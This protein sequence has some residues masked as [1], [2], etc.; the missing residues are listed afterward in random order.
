MW[1][2]ELGTAIQLECVHD[3]LKLAHQTN[4]NSICTRRMLEKVEAMVEEADRQQESF[5]KMP[6]IRP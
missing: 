5:R 2:L 1:T 6:V 4:P 3:A